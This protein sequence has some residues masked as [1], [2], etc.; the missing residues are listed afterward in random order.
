MAAEVLPSKSTFQ[1]TQK[2]F[3][4]KLRSL[5]EGLLTCFTKVFFWGHMPGAQG[6]ITFYHLRFPTTE[7]EHVT[8]QMIVL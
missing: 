6:A 1:Y 7:R 8:G 2:C 3:R 4:P 5:H